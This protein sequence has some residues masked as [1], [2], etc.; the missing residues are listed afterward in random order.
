MT[1][2][3]KKLLAIAENRFKAAP[4]SL[5]PGDDMFEKLKI[6]SIAALNLL[7]ELE[8][9]FGVEIPDYELQGVKTFAELARVIEARR[10]C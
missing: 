2:T 8:M 1:E 6:D 7:S 4:G 9:A 3:T 5:A 10:G